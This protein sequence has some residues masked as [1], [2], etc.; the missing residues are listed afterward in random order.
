MRGCLGVLG[1]ITTA[2]SSLFMVMF[3][4][5]MLTGS[6]TIAVDAGLT[7]FFGIFVAAGIFMARYGLKT[8]PE[9]PID[10]RDLEQRVLNLARHFRGKLTP[11]QVA[12]NA[13]LDIQTSRE[14]LESM[15]TNRVA[16]THVTDGGQIMY[17]FPTFI[18]EEDRDEV[19]MDPLEAEFEAL[20]REEE[21][22]HE[23]V[24]KKS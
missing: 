2:G 15:V 24:Q 13:Q 22:A 11:E 1:L 17:V 14:V 18:S 12:L 16:D 23:Y 7:V 3:L 21:Q 4:I 9:S 8:P 20:A 5:S 6:E 10:R 19:Y